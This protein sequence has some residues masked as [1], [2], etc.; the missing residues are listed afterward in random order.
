MNNHKIIIPTISL[1]EAPIDNKVYARKDSAWVET[2]TKTEIESEFKTST[3]MLYIANLM[4]NYIYK[5][6]DNM[7][8]T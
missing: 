5:N 4:L 7:Y 2:L 3:L 8:I 6:I 1:K